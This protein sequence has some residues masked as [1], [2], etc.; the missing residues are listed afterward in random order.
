MKMYIVG[1]CL[2]IVIG[3]ILFWGSFNP[4][5][6]MFGCFLGLVVVI[7]FGIVLF[8]KMMFKKYSPTEDEQQDSTSYKFGQ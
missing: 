3:I 5:Q 2:C 6:F 1:L 4:S 7:V 8:I